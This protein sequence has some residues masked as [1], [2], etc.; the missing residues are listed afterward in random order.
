[1]LPETLIPERKDDDTEMFQVTKTNNSHFS[2]M[3]NLV[4][5]MKN[6]NFEMKN[7]KMV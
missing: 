1:M 4:F 6:K 7:I 5:E 3:H 2:F